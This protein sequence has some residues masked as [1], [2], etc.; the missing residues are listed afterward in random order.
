MDPQLAAQLRHLGAVH[1]ASTLSHSS[2]ASP[3]DSRSQQ[4]YS[5]TSTNPAQNPAIT[6]LRARDSLAQKAERE[7]LEAGKRGHSGREFLDVVQIRQLL[8]LRDDKKLGSADIEK[9]MGLKK[10]VVDRLGSQGIVGGL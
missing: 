2:T 8:M 3:Q 9:R 10:G 7:F 6:L 1:P 5:A 4:S